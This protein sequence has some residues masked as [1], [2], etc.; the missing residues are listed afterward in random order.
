MVIYV[1]VINDCGHVFVLMFTIMILAL[2]G[3]LVVFIGDRM[4]VTGKKSQIK[5][6]KSV[7]T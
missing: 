3:L 1:F 2:L 5:S 7:T 6:Q 4:K